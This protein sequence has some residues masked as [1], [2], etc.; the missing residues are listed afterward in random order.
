VLADPSPDP[1]LADLVL[2]DTM[3][4]KGA[5]E[6]GQ[7]A[8]RSKDMRRRAGRK[9][10]EREEQ[11]SVREGGARVGEEHEGTREKMNDSGGGLGGAVEA[12]NSVS[13]DEESPGEE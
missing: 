1:V 5:E 8:P 13:W 7:E 4:R 9:G 6:G 2:A 3:Q 10:G 11:R 12:R